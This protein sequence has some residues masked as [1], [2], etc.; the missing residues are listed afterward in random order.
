MA[1]PP[2]LVY[3]LGSARRRLQQW[4]AAQQERA[5]LSGARPPTPAQAGVLFVLARSGGVAMGQLAEALDLAPSATSGLAQRMEALG[6]VARRP[7]PHDART[8]QLWLLPAG[9]AP[10]PGLRTAT[11][12]INQRLTAGFTDAELHTVARWLE[13]IKTLGDPH[14]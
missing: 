1:H 9:Q 7:S 12:Y 10:A 8:L 2:R 3:L 14:D 5:A 13:R 11:Q 4:I 6:W